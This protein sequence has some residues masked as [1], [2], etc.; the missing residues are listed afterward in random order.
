MLKDHKSVKIIYMVSI[1]LC[2]ST[3]G[4]CVHGFYK[5]HKN[6]AIVESM[7]EDYSEEERS[8]APSVEAFNER[9]KLASYM[10]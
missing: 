5:L 3:I 8:E 4:V 2:I 1:A 6:R 9:T 7:Q 10:Q